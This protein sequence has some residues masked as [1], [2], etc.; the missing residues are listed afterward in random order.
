VTRAVA[1]ALVAAAALVGAY[2]AL[3][4]ASGT[5]VTG[6]RDPCRIRETPAPA[7]DGGLARGI[8][9]VALAGLTGAACELGVSRE[10][11]LLGLGGLRDLP[12]G[13]DAER[14]EQAV[15]RGLRRA[16]DEEE[17]AGRLGATEAGLL[18]TGAEL[19]PIDALLRQ[20]L[21]R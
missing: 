12:P 14:R 21:G 6:A 1:V 7:G 5:E 8:E 9:R 16:V 4:G 19:L 15:R 18:R 20:L 3:G 11:L 17:R 13:V 2:L 10:R